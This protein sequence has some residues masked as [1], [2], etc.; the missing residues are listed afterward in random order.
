V[1]GTD[2]LP[3]ALRFAEVGAALSGVDLD[4]RAGQL[5][6][7][8]ARERFDLI[9]SN[10]PFAIGADADGTRVYRDSGSAGDEFCRALVRAA[11]DHLEPGGWCQL[12]AN[13]V[14]RR[15]EDWRDRVG[16]WLPTDVD[17]WVLQRE[18]L[19]PAAYVSLWLRDSGEVAAP[20]YPTRYDKWLEGLERSGVEAIGFGWL[21]LRRT[22]SAAAV[23]RIEEWP[24]PVEHPLGPVVAGAFARIDWLRAHADPVALSAA[25]LCLVD[26]VVQEQRGAPGAE[27][28]TE[29]ILSQ[30]FGLRRR[31]RVDTATAALVGACDG[32]LPIGVLVRAVAEVLGE[33]AEALGDRLLPVIRDLVAEGFLTPPQ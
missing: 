25:R 17:A 11:P 13:W 27:D 5:F 7:P 10:P 3:R 9:V 32:E 14:Y 19:D 26:G 6:D 12:L 33:S 2:V 30:N 31:R 22:D 23:T 15:G 28:P 16:G 21:T 4:L 24:Y 18:V 8:V 1:V 29:V 20:D